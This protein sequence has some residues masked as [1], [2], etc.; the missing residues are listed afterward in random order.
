MVAGLMKGESLT[1][2]IHLGHLQLTLKI[3]RETFD[4]DIMIMKDISKI[5]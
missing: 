3:I 4:P 2:V 5:D 1:L